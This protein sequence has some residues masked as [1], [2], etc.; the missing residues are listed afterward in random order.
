MV[1][2]SV[3]M[4][5]IAREMGVSH[6][7]VSRVVNGQPGVSP[8]LARKIRHQMKQAGYRP[9]SSVRRPAGPSPRAEAEV[10]TRTLG[11]VYVGPPCKNLPDDYSGL[12]NAVSREVA[13]SDYNLLYAETEDLASAPSWLAVGKV[14]GL[15]MLGRP[16]DASLLERIA[17]IPQVW[18]SS[19][20]LGDHEPAGDRVISGNYA[21]GQLAATYLI[22]RGHQRLAYINPLG[23]WAVYQSRGDAFEI[24][25]RRQGVEVNRYESPADPSVDLYELTVEELDRRAELLVAQLLAQP[26]RPTGVFAPDATMAYPFYRSAARQGLVVGR[27]VDV[28]TFGKSQSCMGLLPRPACMETKSEL[29]ALRAVNQLLWRIEHPGEAWGMEVA[30]EP[31]V[32]EGEAAWPGQGPESRI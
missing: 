27:D 17:Q 7:T 3:S 22:Q 19:H 6:T 9:R 31:V 24:T 11:F 20:S 16:R 28:I 1:S 30:I 5:D 18:L 4:V 13:K 15:L 8:A 12:L 2:D 25:A 21:V 14:A 26:Q 23:G 29:R 10:A 32:V